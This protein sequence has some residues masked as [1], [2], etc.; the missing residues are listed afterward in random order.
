M[1]AEPSEKVPI[2]P[3]LKKQEFI[4]EK[5]IMQS[6]VLNSSPG[7]SDFNFIHV[8]STY[9]TT[10]LPYVH[11]STTVSIRT[12]VLQYLEYATIILGFV[13]NIATVLTLNKNGTA[14]S[15]AIL[16][17]FS[18]QSGID[19]MLC[20]LTALYN[21][22]PSMWLT[23]IY[24]IDLFICHTWHSLTINATLMVISVW[25]LVLIA[26]ERF[27]AIS[28][29]F[30]HQNLTKYKL[31]IFKGLIYLCSTLV[32][33]PTLFQT[34][35]RNNTCYPESHFKNKFGQ[36]LQEVSRVWAFITDVA[37]PFILFIVFYGSV[38][39]TFRQ[40]RK[41]E[42]MSSSNIINKATAQLT[43]TAIVVT[44]IFFFCIGYAHL[45]YMFQGLGIIKFFVV[46][47]ASFKIGMWLMT[48]NSMANPF[49]YASLMPAYR[50]S[51]MKT[52]CVKN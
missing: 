13:A 7:V 33:L 48:V 25:N 22:L 1:R 6:P 36:V 43:K 52:F 15:E 26:F 27:L 3:K 45:L 34:S 18:H 24:H 49:V 17:L 4:L 30:K 11:T 50:R 38:L 8:N 37:T 35:L 51:I 41:S 5:S 40:R 28:Y 32:V 16:V 42:N 46:N 9:A 10:I 2:I 14:F 19:A 20:L 47:T 39:Y 31:R 23:G 21:W 44:V 29:P 12:L